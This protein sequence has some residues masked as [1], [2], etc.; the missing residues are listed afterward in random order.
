[1]KNIDL[2]T[3]FRSILQWFGTVAYFSVGN[4][5]NELNAEIRR[6]KSYVRVTR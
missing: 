3:G 4:P 5:E 6:K 2:L 1:M